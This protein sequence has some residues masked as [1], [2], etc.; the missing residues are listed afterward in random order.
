MK[1]RA[2]SLFLAAVMA[3]GLAA[4]AFAAEDVFLAEEPAVEE[5]AAPEAPAPMEEPAPAEPEQ[6]APMDQPGDGAMDAPD[7]AAVTPEELEDEPVPAANAAYDG[8]DIQAVWDSVASGGGTLTL[9]ADATVESSLE[10]TGGNVTLT[11][12]HSMTGSGGS[13][14]IDVYTGTLNITGGASVRNTGSGYAVQA[15]GSTVTVNGGTVGKMYAGNRAGRDGVVNVSGGGVIEDLEVLCHRVTVVS[16]TVKNMTVTASQPCTVN[17]YSGST[18]GT[19]TVNSG[20]A[21][22]SSFGTVEDLTVDGGTVTVT[23]GTVTALTVNGG[24]VNVK[25]GG[26]AGRL[27]VKE[28]AAG[29]VNVSGGRVGTLHVINNTGDEITD[30]TVSVSGGTVN[31]LRTDK[32]IT[33]T[34]NVSGG[35]VNTLDV[36]DRGTAN[37]SGGYVGN[38]GVHSATANVSGGSVD[39]LFV[40]WSTANITGGTIGSMKAQGTGN[41]TIDGGTIGDLAEK[42][43]YT[44]TTI[45]NGQINNISTTSRSHVTIGGDGTTNLK[46][47]TMNMDGG[48]ASFWVGEFTTVNIGSS[49]VVA[50][51]GGKFGTVHDTAARYLN[52]IRIYGG[53]F[54]EFISDHAGQ[55][56]Y[57]TYFGTVVY[58]RNVTVM[59]GTF[60]Y[61]QAPEGVS[62]N[63]MILWSTYYAFY[64]K[65]GNYVYAGGNTIRNVTASGI[66]TAEPTQEPAAVSDL[67]YDGNAHNLVTRGEAPH[68]R[69]LYSIAQDGAYSTAIPRGTNAGT[70]QVWWKVQGDDGYNDYTPEGPITVTIAQAPLDGVTLP[71]ANNGLTYNGGKQE[72]LASAGEVTGSGGTMEYALGTETEAPAADSDWK[73]AH[74]EITA[75]KAGTY[76]VWYKVTSSDPNHTYGGPWCV[77]VTIQKAASG[78]TEQPV[79]AADWSFDNVEYPLLVPGGTADGGT[80]MYAVRTDESAPA[81]GDWKD[82]AGLITGKDPGTYYVWYKIEGD[83]NHKDTAPV[84]IGEVVVGNSEAKIGEKYYPTLQEAVDA[85]GADDIVLWRD[86]DLDAAVDIASDVTLSSEKDAGGTPLPVT[87]SGTLNITGEGSLTVDSAVTVYGVKTGEGMKVPM[88]MEG[89][90]TVEALDGGKAKVTFGEG[91]A[92]YLWVGDTTISGNITNGVYDT[93]TVNT[94]GSVTVPLT[95]NGE[96]TIDGRTYTSKGPAKVTIYQD[97]SFKMDPDDGTVTWTVKPGA[98]GLRLAPDAAVDCG[99]VTLKGMRPSGGT[100][101]IDE[102]GSVTV[103][104]GNVTVKGDVSVEADAGARFTQLGDVTVYVTDESGAPVEGAAVRIGFLTGTTGADGA[105][106]IRDVPY[107]LQNVTV[108]KTN[109]AGKVVTA[110]GTVT[111]DWAVGAAG[112]V[113]LPSVTVNTKV[114]SELPQPPAVE[115]LDSVIT[116]EDKADA[117]GKDAVITVSLSANTLGAGSSGGMDWDDVYEI[118]ESIQSAVESIV[119]VKDP[120]SAITDYIDVTVTKTVTVGDTDTTGSVPETSGL[121]T[122][123]FPLSSGLKAKLTGNVTAD[124]IFVLRQHGKDYSSVEVMQKVSPSYGMSA[125]IECYYIQQTGGNTYIVIRANQFSVYAFGVAAAAVEDETPGSGYIPSTPATPSPSPTPTPGPGGEPAPG[126]GGDEPT[127]TPTPT[128]GP[129]GDKPTAPVEPPKTNGGTGWSYD[130]GTGEW[131]FFKKG[132]LVANYWVG[133]IDGASQWDNNWYYVG[134]DGKMLTGMQYLDDLKGGRAWYML[135]TTNDRQE[136]GKMLTGWQW[137]YAAAGEGYFSPK[138]GSQ[139]MCTWTEAWGSYNAATGLWTDGL[140]HKG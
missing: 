60:D 49:T 47:G 106:V 111:V 71:T 114:S 48:S 126:P 77:A 62:V 125:G 12:A 59:G 24:T 69:V 76:Y 55:F 130:Y 87:V 25:S 44:M 129:G 6:D 118:K 13:P 19:M 115:G 27:T 127:P 64:D 116:A 18:V 78:V 137:T 31:E 84:K 30:G 65:N 11:G 101:D 121:L 57:T 5:P 22:I 109:T 8:G 108:T 134:A 28:G 79:L 40:D 96:M 38:L 139:G 56:C 34:V 10:L 70:Y 93:V 20:T 50:I 7:L 26:E 138:Y 3:F 68:G 97:G 61:I 21:G 136:I 45:I 29:A 53:E 113:I 105:A 32:F 72:L 91:S 46:I 103:R 66:R 102:Y 14:T 4:P 110:S 74:T 90:V 99:G 23:G 140:S 39:S 80:M 122:L 2:L 128:P 58:D 33:V 81:E 63:A 67:T 95:E 17:V 35:T 52:T 83:E 132:A 98:T 86:L 85:A 89:H 82:S 107:G 119:G 16:G 124:N 75:V 112:T 1:K 73:T 135:Q 133:K 92:N 51:H 123:T 94:D 100:V 41:V 104:E 88:G 117:A 54:D 131:Y 9:N 37:V 120:A 36:W 42:M 15:E 43:F